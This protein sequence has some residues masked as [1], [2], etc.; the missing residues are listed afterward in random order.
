MTTS[1][2]VRLSD[3]DPHQ[4]KDEDDYPWDL[5]PCELLVDEL[6]MVLTSRVRMP[7]ID[8]MPEINAS[9]L[10]YGINDSFVSDDETMSR[11]IVL[12][13]RITKAMQR[14]EPRLANF[15]VSRAADESEPEIMIF[16]ITAHYEGALITVALKWNDMTGQ[17][18]IYE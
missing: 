9:V 2:L 3:N 4:D 12:E 15:S 17:F 6:K 8:N 13:E 18:Y 7:D 10:N 1:L 14:F 11:Y 5:L 16:T